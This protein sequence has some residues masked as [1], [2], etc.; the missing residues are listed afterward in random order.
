VPAPLDPHAPPPTRPPVPGQQGRPPSGGQRPFEVLDR[1][2]GLLVCEPSPLAL[3]G[4]AVGHGLPARPIPLGQLRRLLL[5]S[6]VGFDARDAALTWL[7]G[8]AQRE[9]GGWLVGV[10]GVLL[11]GMARRVYPLC[12]AYP[13]LAP[14]LE[15][16]ALAGLLEAVKGW[17]CG[18]DRVATRLVWAAT[19]A[20]HR[21]LRRELTVADREASIGLE[22]ELP[23]RPAVH[24]ELVLDEAVAT[25]GGVAAR[26]RADRRLPHRGG[27]GAG[28]G[29]AVGGWL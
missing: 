21:L 3:D 24:G 5:D 12:R 16:E 6:S 14:D 29:Q 25:G 10:A 2:F 1:S 15:A 4:A 11:P 20:A 8:R 9:G 22:L 13:R 28:A 27:P 26:R 19:R 18:K 23:A 7:V 17:P